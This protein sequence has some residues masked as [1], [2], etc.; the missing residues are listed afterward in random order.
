VRSR[1]A[2]FLFCEVFGQ[3]SHISIVDDADG[4]HIT[5]RT[6]MSRYLRNWYV[7]FQPHSVVFW[8]PSPIPCLTIPSI[9]RSLSTRGLVERVLRKMWS[10]LVLI[11]P[12]RRSPLVHSTNARSWPRWSCVKASWKLGHGPS[13]GA[14]TLLRKSTYPTQSEGL[15]IVHS[16]RLFDIPFVSTMALKALEQEHSLAVYS[17]ILE[18]HPSST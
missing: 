14:T 15:T 17:P 7:D 10:V 4:P 11:P 6:L 16:W 3:F 13:L 5:P 9:P 2:I 8:L 12:S 18:S 1:G